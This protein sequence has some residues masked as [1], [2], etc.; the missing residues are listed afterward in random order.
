[1]LHQIYIVGY[2]WVYI[3]K[4]K[5]NGLVDQYKVFFV[6]KGF[7]QIYNIDYFETLSCGSS[8]LH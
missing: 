7:F 1:M 4:Y 5:P 2:R 3:I 6:A 8:Q